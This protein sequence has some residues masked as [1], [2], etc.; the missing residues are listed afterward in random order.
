MNDVDLYI[1]GHPGDIKERLSE[2]RKII[3]E[4]APDAI[5]K[6]SFRMPA[7]Q[8]EG[9]TFIFFGAFKKHVGLYPEPAAIAAFADKLTVYKT[10][11]GAIQFPYNK[12]FPK[13][14]I[15]EIVEYRVE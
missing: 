10:S 2:L 1:D 13:D 9:K 3:F 12:P 6:I 7:Y 5:E 14:L 11:T 8:L 4:V 15:R